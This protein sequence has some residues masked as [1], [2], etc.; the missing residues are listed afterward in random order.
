MPCSYPLRGSLGIGK[1]KEALV[2]L[3][4][5]EPL[6]QPSF[7]EVKGLMSGEGRHID[8]AAN[9]N[10]RPSEDEYQANTNNLF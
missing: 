8:L 5:K 3:Y 10:C 2:F 7:P 4:G 1:G 9:S 6:P